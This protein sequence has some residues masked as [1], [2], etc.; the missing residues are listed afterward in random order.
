[1]ALWALPFFSENKR[2]RKPLGK[3]F[4]D[5][6]WDWWVGH[7]MPSTPQSANVGLQTTEF[8]KWQGTQPL[9]CSSGESDLH[10]WAFLSSDDYGVQSRTRS[11]RKLAREQN[12]SQS[13]LIEAV[14]NGRG[15]NGCISA[16]S[17]MWPTCQRSW[18]L[19]VSKSWWL[20]AHL[21]I[22]SWGGS[23]HFS[24]NLKPR[25][26]ERGIWF[27]QLACETR[28]AKQ[29]VEAALVCAPSVNRGAF[30]G[31][32]GTCKCSSFQWTKEHLDSQVT[33]I[34]EGF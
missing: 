33:L 27:K 10:G 14:G 18:L 32:L 5:N 20:N 4:G 22:N 19:Q 17:H 28:P 25:W 13:I 16:C 23:P 1:M 24:S 15:N 8:L 12:K 26:S 30:F 2:P 3:A 9:V 29:Q 21:L 11:D 34:S 6:S 7:E 31:D